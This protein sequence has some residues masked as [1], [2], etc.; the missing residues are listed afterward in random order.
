MTNTCVLY[1]ICWLPDSEHLVPVISSHSSPSYHLCQCF[2]QIVIITLPTYLPM[3]YSHIRHTFT[4]WI[5]ICSVI[6]ISAQISETWAPTG[7]YKLIE[8]RKSL[9]HYQCMWPTLDQQ[10]LYY[11][12]LFDFKH[13]L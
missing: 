2:V 13:Q 1:C 6:T 4:H 7:D 12:Y 8:I 5:R 11:F 9:I 3:I 10:I